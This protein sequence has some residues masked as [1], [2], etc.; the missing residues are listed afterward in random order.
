MQ[1]VASSALALAIAHSAVAS[2]IQRL[3]ARQSACSDVHVFLA[4]GNNEPYPG[5]QGVLV[6]A[7]CSGLPSCDYEDIQYYNPVE[8]PYCDSINQGVAD[9]VAQITA[10]N[11]RCPN[12]KLVVSGY[13]QGAQIV[14]DLLGGGGGN[15]FQNCLE[16][17]TP[18]LDVNSAPGN[19]SKL[20]HSV[21]H[22]K[23]QTMLT[24]LQLPPP[25]RS[26]TQGTP[27]VSPTMS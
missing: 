20:Q 17:T 27:V 10:Y 16:T 6:N 22:R 24:A 7:I 15:F 19:A 18:G 12:S 11:A 1:F 14:S 25:S 23:E 3:E 26:A 4:K 5:R 9:G 21:E 13:S 2:T 8:A